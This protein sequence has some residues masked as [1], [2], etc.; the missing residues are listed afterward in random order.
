MFVFAGKPRYATPAASL[1]AVS[2]EMGRED[3]RADAQRGVAAWHTDMAHTCSLLHTVVLV[4]VHKRTFTHTDVLS[5][6]LTHTRTDTHKRTQIQYRTIVYCLE[7][8]K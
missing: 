4:H 8:I 1:A 7:Q 3:R 6:T 5:H 2:F